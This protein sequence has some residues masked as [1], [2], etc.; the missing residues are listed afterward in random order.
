MMAKVRSGHVDALARQVEAMATGPEHAAFIRY[1]LG[2]ARLID[3]SGVFDEKLWRE[4]RLSLRAL[5][6]SVGDQFGPDE[7]EELWALKGRVTG[8]AGPPLNP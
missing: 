5:Q 4:Y 1:A 3:A 7:L 8:E 2:L 6:E